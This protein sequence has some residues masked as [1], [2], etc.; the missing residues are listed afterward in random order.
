MLRDAK[1][2]KACAE[3]KHRLGENNNLKNFVKSCG[4]IVSRK[5]KMGNRLVLEIPSHQCDEILY[6]KDDKILLLLHFAA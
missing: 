5:P 6:K 3:L 1:K 2:K 4:R